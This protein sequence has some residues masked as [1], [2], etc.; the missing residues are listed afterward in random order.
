MFYLNCLEN[1]GKFFV[2]VG[3]KLYSQIL[4]SNNDLSYDLLKTDT[5]F[6]EQV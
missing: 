1:F 5:I 3:S 4:K 6:L 2:N